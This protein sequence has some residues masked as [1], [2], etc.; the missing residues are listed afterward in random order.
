MDSEKS[1]V[2]QSFQP[3]GVPA[4]PGATESTLSE[5]TLSE[6]PTGPGAT[7]PGR[8]PHRPLAAAGFGWL[9]L[10]ISVGFRFDFGLTSASGFHSLGS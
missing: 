3:L 8:L 1:M 10:R 5:S 6:C 2:L 9:A 7:E 4:G